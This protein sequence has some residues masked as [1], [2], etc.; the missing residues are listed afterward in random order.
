[1][2]ADAISYADDQADVADAFQKKKKK[3][4][5]HVVHN[6]AGHS[7]IVVVPP[8]QPAAAAHGLTSQLGDR[9]LALVG[10]SD[11]AR[12]CAGRVRHAARP[13]GGQARPRSVA[14]R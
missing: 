3:N 8:K 14:P 12:G 6:H 7:W 1:M 10:G 13:G 4:A 2:D 5:F 9:R 11:G